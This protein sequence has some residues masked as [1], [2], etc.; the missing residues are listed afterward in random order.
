MDGPQF[1][2]EGL[3]Q[4]D[5]VATVQGLQCLIAN[6]L[7]IAVTLIGF[8]G[9]VMM[10]VAAFRYLVSSGNSKQTE[11]ARNAITF[12]VIGLVLALG[13]VTILYLVSQ[14]TGI[15]LILNFKIPTDSTTI[16]SY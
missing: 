4:I 13:S 10:I 7:S 3:C 12:A 15:E 2:S 9:L 16:D 11:T 8:A 14:F 1:W 5:G 6:I